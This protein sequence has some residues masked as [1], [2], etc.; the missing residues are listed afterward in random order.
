MEHNKEW[1]DLRELIH[2]HSNSSSWKSSQYVTSSFDEA[3]YIKVNRNVLEGAAK[4]NGI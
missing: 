2:V 1:N 4:I 3:H